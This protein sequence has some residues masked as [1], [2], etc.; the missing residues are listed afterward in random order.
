MARDF[1]L[2]ARGVW[3]CPAWMAPEASTACEGW[4][5]KTRCAHR[6]AAPAAAPEA[7]VV[8]VATA[9]TEAPGVVG[10]TFILALNARRIALGSRAKPRRSCARWEAPEVRV[11]MEAWGVA[12]AMAAAAAWAHPASRRRGMGRT[13]RRRP[14]VYQVARMAGEA[15]TGCK[16]TVAWRV[17]PACPAR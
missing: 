9:A 3:E 15:A 16:G 8:R 11:A 2:Q 17:Q 10:A 7:A 6:A 4:M 13:S 1:R 14:I 12:V 5:V